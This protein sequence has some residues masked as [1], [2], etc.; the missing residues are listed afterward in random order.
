MDRML[1]AVFVMAESGTI[2][3][4]YSLSSNSVKR[5]LV[6]ETILK[7]LPKSYHN[8]PATLL[9]RLAVDIQFKGQGL[10]RLLLI[11]ALK[12][13]YDN[14]KTSSGS[15]AVVVDP[16]DDEAIKF[17]RKFGFIELADSKKMFMAMRTISKLF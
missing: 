16:L 4:Y 15:M 10:G 1:T 17:Y 12:R 8:L 9:G 7:K 13:S 14:S 2:K 11:D 5:E 6:P 3:G